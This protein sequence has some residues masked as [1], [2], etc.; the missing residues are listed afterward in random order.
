M[1]KILRLLLVL[2]VL[3]S[4]ICPFHE[5]QAAEVESPIKKVL[6]FGDSMTGWMAER[7]NA[8]GQK[9]GF[10]VAT[11]IWDGSTIKKWANSG[12]LSTIIREQDPDVVFISLGLNELFERNPEASLGASLSKI[13]TALGNT[14]Y[15]W[16]G[17]PSW[18][19]KSK[20]EKLN[21]WLEKSLGKSHYFN[22]SELQLSRQSKTNPHPSKAGICKWIDTVM[23]WIPSHTDLD[24][25]SVAPPAPNAMSR[26]KVFIYK[27][28]KES[29]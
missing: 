26:G 1:S 24:F 2:P 29:L 12:K 4:M 20:G 16:I 5:A 17:P 19:G 10:T 22:S 23:E 18:P 11:V 7:L 27:R 15:L 14:P 28:M 3:L 6:F 9:D 21:E 25:T 13:K 8:F